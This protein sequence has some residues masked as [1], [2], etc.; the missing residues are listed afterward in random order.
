MLSMI[1]GRQRA[2]K[3]YYCLT[4]VIE[5]LQT[6]K[7]HIYTDLPVNPDVL[8]DFACGGKNKHYA[9]YVSMLERIHLFV[10][11][12]GRERKNYKIFKSLNPDYISMHKSHKKETF[13]HKIKGREV[14]FYSRFE[15]LFIPKE[16]MHEFW[17]VTKFR[18]IVF[19][20]EAYECFGSLDQ[21]SHGAE[22][23]QQLL[24]YT[25]QH[26]HFKDDIF[27]ISH[28]ECDID[29]IIRNGLE[30]HIVVK[31]SKFENVS[32]KRFARGFRWPI[33]FFMIDVF[34]YGDK[35]PS[36]FFHIFPD[37]HI[38][39]CYNSFSISTVIGKTGDFDD[40]DDDHCP[41]V[42]QKAN[43]KNFSRQLLPFL[44]F[45]VASV[46]GF[47]WFLWT[48]IEQLGNST[49]S[50]VNPNQSALIGA[51]AP[52]PVIQ[53]P[54]SLV[55]FV[56]PDCIIFSNKQTIKRGDFYHDYKVEKIFSDSVVLSRNGHIGR[57][58]FSVLCPSEPS[59]IS[60]TIKV[61]GSVSTSPGGAPKLATPSAAPVS[62]VRS[63]AGQP[64][65]IGSGI[66]AIGQGG[67]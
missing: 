50:V 42:D 63:I 47:G 3:T 44:A 15:P 56:S 23:R 52:G 22:I 58:S 2:G 43:I 31:N 39:K 33:Q 19:I 5:F 36:D 4:V 38:F 37:K 57:F 46:V 11:F 7:R 55:K 21:R 54:K 48:L 45:A 51:A 20:D 12:R 32:E 9:K 62:P 64:P 53:Q 65:V 59:T 29:K 8:A 61:A 40:D 16:L 34:M 18:S 6:T 66:A 1:S 24:S 10:S 17:K 25:R 60:S 41:G 49:T 26:N 30:K 27:L 67:R 28:K 35:K 14:T 13:K